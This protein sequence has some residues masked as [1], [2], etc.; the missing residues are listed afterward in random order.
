MRWEATSLQCVSSYRLVLL[1]TRAAD[2]LDRP[3]INLLDHWQSRHRHS[4]HVLLPS[5]S[6]PMQSLRRRGTEMAAEEERG[7]RPQ[8][9][10]QIRSLAATCKTV[11][12]AQR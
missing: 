5:P 10:I 3:A 6:P 11:H 7:L 1:H 8:F 12:Q 4:R 2:K 9:S